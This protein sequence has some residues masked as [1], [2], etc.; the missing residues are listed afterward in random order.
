MHPLQAAYDAENALQKNVAQFASDP[1]GVGAERIAKAFPMMGENP[2]TLRGQEAA[3]SAL[4]SF[5][6]GATTKTPFA[7][8]FVLPTKKLQRLEDSGAPIKDYW[9]DAGSFPW[10]YDDGSKVYLQALHN[11]R[12]NF[13]SSKFRQVKIGDKVPM[14]DF[15]DDPNIRKSYPGLLDNISLEKIKGNGARFNNRTGDIGI[16]EQ[17]MGKTSGAIHEID[18]FIQKLSGL[19][20]GSNPKLIEAAFKNDPTGKHFQKFLPELK[21]QLYSMAPR[22]RNRL[23]EQV[24]KSTPG[25]ALAF[26]AQRG[27]SHPGE[28]ATAHPLRMWMNQMR[29]EGLKPRM[30]DILHAPNLTQNLDRIQK[31][32]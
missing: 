22:A 10:R 8:D 3:E 25:E 2:R 20:S 13:D 14:S 29:S 4:S 17:L 21:K 26:L 5:G 15:F 6:F 24:Y 32:K 1:I 11:A 9:K 23:I 18:H 19:Q 27:F 12:A 30:G 16:G 7:D 28:Y 31:A